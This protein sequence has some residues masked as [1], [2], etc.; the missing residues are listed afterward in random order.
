MF[1]DFLP[2]DYSAPKSTGRYTKLQDGDNVRLRILTS[3]VMFWEWWSQDNKPIRFK[4]EKDAIISAPANA[5]DTK[6]KFVWAVVVWNYAS[7]KTEIWSISQSSLRK[8]L[9]DCIRD[10]DIGN[11]K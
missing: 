5:R 3:P 4:Y 10:P 6:G 7:E 9:E 1:D 2:A 8:Y 11:P